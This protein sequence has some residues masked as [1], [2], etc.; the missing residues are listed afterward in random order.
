MKRIYYNILIVFKVWLASMDYEVNLCALNH[1]H[2]HFILDD[3]K[4]RLQWYYFGMPQYIKDFFYFE[5]MW[6]RKKNEYL[7]EILS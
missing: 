3:Y 5:A 2:L 7:K 4:Q 6:N 1:S